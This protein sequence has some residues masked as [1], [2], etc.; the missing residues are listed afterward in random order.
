M[1]DITAVAHLR[2]ATAAPYWHRRTAFEWEEKKVIIDHDKVAAEFLYGL[3]SDALDD[4]RWASKRAEMFLS[5]ESSHK[6]H[7]VIA[8][9]EEIKEEYLK[10]I[11]SHWAS[12]RCD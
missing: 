3:I 6:L 7:Y 10:N 2:R 12:L 11:Q 8:N 1:Y 4:L 9:L 5:I